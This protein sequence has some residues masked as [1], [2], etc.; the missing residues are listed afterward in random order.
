MQDEMG[1]LLE[2]LPTVGAAEGPLLCVDVPVVSQ[3][4]HPPK[5]IPTFKHM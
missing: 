1:V 2:A 5:A 4:G 3:A